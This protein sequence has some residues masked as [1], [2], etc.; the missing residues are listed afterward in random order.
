MRFL[1]L[2]V[3][4]LAAHGMAQSRV[5]QLPPTAPEA[6]AAAAALRQGLPPKVLFDR[7]RGTDVW[8]IGHDWKAGFDGRGVTYIPFFGS[9]A[10]QNFPLRFELAEV[11]VGAERLALPAGTPREQAGTVATDRGAL[12][13]TVAT[14][15]DVVEQS[16]VFHELPNRGAIHVDLAVQT[17]LQ[18]TV[19]AE[20]LR[21]ANEFGAVHYTKAVAIDATGAR[22][23]LPI[24]WDGDSVHMTIPADFVANAKLPLVLDPLIDTNPGIRPGE[25]LAQR[26]PDTATLQSPNRSLVVYQRTWSAT[27][28]D[29]Y[30]EALDAN[31]DRVNL[32][33]LVLDATA[34]SWISPEVASSQFAGNYLVVAQSSLGGIT[35][36]VSRLVN[37]NGTVTS[38]VVDVERAGSVGLPGNNFA[39]D[40]GGDPFGGTLAY[41]CVVWQHATTASNHDIHYKLVQ[42]DGS[43]L[44]PMP[45]VLSGDPSFESR[46]SISE[47]NRTTEWRVAFERQ[48][49]VAPFD[50]NIFGGGIGWEGTLTRPPYAIDTTTAFDAFPEVS[51]PIVLANG[52]QEVHLVVWDRTNGTQGDIVGNF[53]GI[54]GGNLGQFNLDNLE[55]GGAFAS[56]TRTVPGTDADGLR[57][58]VGYSE[59]N[60]TDYDT[61]ATTVR[62]DAAFGALLDDVRQPLGATP[63]IENFKTGIAAY[64]SAGLQQSSRYVIAS[65]NTAFNDIQVYDYGGYQAGP[66]FSPFPTQCGPL[67]VTPSGEPI[68]G[69]TVTIVANTLAPYGFVFGFPGFIGLGPLGCNCT[70]GVDQGVL[71]SG[72]LVFTIPPNTA[73]VGTALSAQAYGA[74][75]TNCFGFLALSDT[76]DF[77][78]R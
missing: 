30:A 13:E 66:F 63:G 78:V 20:G 62:F 12:V 65:H 40:V 55:A 17:S 7:P 74:T 39:P 9:E 14:T 8:A 75:G 50:G 37:G 1:L 41:Y 15:T 36:I 61:Y 42:Q 3:C 51:S 34:E 44:N 6:P 48:R 2:P 11:R 64:H 25:T 31:L 26:N 21:F 68:V 76:I 18:A 69:G 28:Q 43:L 27:D 22:Q 73:I 53:V 72:P 35:F 5:P 49:T 54:D 46:P 56:R 23:S 38:Q 4:A 59:F 47:T 19:L 45:T 29:C 10:P 67:T 70:L 57:F 52:G 71:V 32:F 77:T 24:T 33:T 60:G 16:F 58:V